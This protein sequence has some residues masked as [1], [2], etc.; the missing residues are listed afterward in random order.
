M[1]YS[2]LRSGRGLNRKTALK[3]GA[4][5]KRKTRLK[6]VSAKRLAARPEHDAI[7]QRVFERDGGCVLLSLVPGHVCA[8]PPTVHHKAKSGQGGR[9]VE[10]NL[11]QVCAIG[12]GVWLETHRAEAEA[13]G[14]HVPGWKYRS[15]GAA[16]TPDGAAG[17]ATDLAQEQG[18]NG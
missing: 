1:T 18:T 12:N 3:P 16:N 8:G 17:R 9:Y 7:R 2:T 11:V 13:L 15:G 4:P 5:P 6:P 10:S 14:L